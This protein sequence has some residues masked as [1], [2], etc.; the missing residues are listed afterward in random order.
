MTATTDDSLCNEKSNIPCAS[1]VPVLMF[2]AFFSC[3]LSAR[4]KCLIT[5]FPVIIELWVS[6][7]RPRSTFQASGLTYGRRERIGLAYLLMLPQVRVD[8]HKMTVYIGSTAL[9]RQKVVQD[10]SVLRQAL[11]VD[12]ILSLKKLKSKKEGVDTLVWMYMA[13]LPYHDKKW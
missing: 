9:S 11:L 10:M 13:A 4:I 5:L 2:N 7:K 3:V 6:H 8:D 1:I 12:I